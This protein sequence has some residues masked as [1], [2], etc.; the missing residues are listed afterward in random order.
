MRAADFAFYDPPFLALAHRGGA[1]Y[2]PNRGRENTLHA[3]HEA[4]ALG[5]SYLETDVHATRD[6]VLLAFHDDRVDR[7]TDAIGHLGDLSYAQVQEVRVNGVDPVPTLAE[8][9]EAFPDARFSVDA[10][11]DAAVEPLAEVIAEHEAY[12]RVCVGSFDTRRVH[13]L[14]RRLGRPVASFASPVG[15]GLNR[16][17]PWLTQALNSDAAALSV[18]LTWRLAGRR[19]Q[20][21]TP[22]LVRTAHRAGKAVLVWTVDDATVME[23][24]IDAGVDGI[25]TDRPERLR[26]V[27]TG[28]GLW[29]R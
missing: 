8:L 3:F 18:P 29:P 21:L 4:V 9:L 27:L 19:C 14:R 22:R 23:S 17:A 11:S 15:I 7:V 10:K 26:A 25:F 1:H 16:F 20:V 2:P 28:R 5:Y 6:G 12:E 24:L 13:R